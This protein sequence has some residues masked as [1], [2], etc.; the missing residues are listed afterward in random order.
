MD[1]YTRILDEARRAIAETAEVPA[2][3]IPPEAINGYLAAVVCHLCEDLARLTRERD[4]ADAALALSQEAI[5][6]YANGENAALVRTEKAERRIADALVAWWCGQCD[7]VVL[8]PGIE[9][10]TVNDRIASN[11]DTGL[12]CAGCFDRPIRTR[13]VPDPEP[14]PADAGEE[15]V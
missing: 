9:D 15:E 6:V 11:T 12:R 3:T 5:Q 1:K 8:Y 10:G 7:W 13:I 14:E 2:S 4:E